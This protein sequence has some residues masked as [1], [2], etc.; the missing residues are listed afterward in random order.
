M[1]Y[2]L[3]AYLMF[4]A[5]AV[6]AQTKLRQDDGSC[7]ALHVEVRNRGYTI[8]QHRLGCY[9]SAQECIAQGDAFVAQVGSVRRGMEVV[10]ECRKSVRVY[11]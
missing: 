7:Y 6:G 9:P 2:L 1:K 10:S 5:A 8:Q 3:F 11:R 4:A